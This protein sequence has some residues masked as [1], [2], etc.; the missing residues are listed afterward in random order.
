MLERGQPISSQASR[1]DAGA[2]AACKAEI[3]PTDEEITL[4]SKIIQRFHD[5]GMSKEVAVQRMAAMEPFD[6]M[7]SAVRK[8]SD[9][10]Y[11]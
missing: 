1:A 9:H 7:A 5:S 4:I 8:I 11:L 10:I 6:S 3:P 2:G